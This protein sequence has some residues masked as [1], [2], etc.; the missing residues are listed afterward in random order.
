MKHRRHRSWQDPSAPGGMSTHVQLVRMDSKGGG[1]RGGGGTG[2]GGGGGPTVLTGGSPPLRP[3]WSVGLRGGPSVPRER[4]QRDHGA[5]PSVWPRTRPACR[6]WGPVLRLLLTGPGRSQEASLWLI[7]R[8]DVSRGHQ[9][10][11]H[12]PGHWLSELI[13]GIL[14]R[15]RQQGAHPVPQKPTCYAQIIQADLCGFCSRPPNTA[16]VT[17]K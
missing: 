7:C 1:G 5:R 13:P 8:V 6:A 4:H 17:I 2:Q 15:N 10:G 16:N 11:S 12:L 9:W 3:P 14:I